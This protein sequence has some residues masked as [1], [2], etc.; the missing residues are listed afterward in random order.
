MSRYSPRSPVNSSRNYYSSGESHPRKNQSDAE[1]LRRFIT[2]K[3]TSSSE[4]EE[5]W[6][7]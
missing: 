4:D 3:T 5:F 2:Y 1:F 7:D 6:P